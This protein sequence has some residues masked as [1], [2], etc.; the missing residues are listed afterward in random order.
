MKA[1]KV[2]L[3]IFVLSLFASLVFAILGALFAIDDV[4]PD[5][6]TWGVGI[7]FGVFLCSLVG[8]LLYVIW[9]F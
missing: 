9:I 2:L 6:A 4:I 5:W 1:T 3:S 8:S 7:S